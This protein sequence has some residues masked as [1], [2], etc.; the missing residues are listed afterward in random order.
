[1]GKRIISQRRGRGTRRFIS[2]RHRYIGPARNKINLKNEVHTAEVVCLH[3]SPAHSAPLAHVVYDDG[4]EGLMIAP[5]GIAVGDV[6]ST[7]KTSE[8]R[9]G[10][11]LRLG[12]IPEGTAI[13]NI[14]NYKGDGGRYVRASGTAARV[15]A[16][17]G[18]TVSVILPSKK[19][20]NFSAN[21][22]ATI[23]NVAGGGRLDK[24]MLKAGANW[25]AKRARGKLYPVTS[26]VAMNANEHPFGCGRGRHM[27]KPSIAPRYAPPGRK[28]GLIHPRRTGRRR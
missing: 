23:G 11:T 13:Y 26:A 5:E 27:G 20:K 25:H 8:I 1:M 14:E 24:P 22:M 6:I 4:E 16:N 9:P 10:N 18:Q 15:L 12:D 2:L 7:G 3:H 17:M 21:C 19:Q 28:V